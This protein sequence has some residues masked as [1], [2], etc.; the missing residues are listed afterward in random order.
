MGYIKQMLCMRCEEDAETN[1]GTLK[2]C[3][4]G[5]WEVKNACAD[6]EGR[7]ASCLKEESG[8]STACGECINRTTQQCTNVKT[9]VAGTDLLIGHLY[10]CEG[11]YGNAIRRRRFAYVLAAGETCRDTCLLAAARIR[12]ALVFLFCTR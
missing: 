3:V 8:I 2:V 6:D 4:Q 7:P 12:L 10:I 11:G 5:Q 1:A 9:S